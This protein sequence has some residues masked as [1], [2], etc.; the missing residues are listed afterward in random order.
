[1]AGFTSRCGAGIQHPLARLRIDEPGRQLRARVLH[2]L[3][4]GGLDGGVEGGLQAQQISQII[5][6]GDSVPMNP[7]NPLDA[8]NRRIVIMVLNSV[9]EAQVEAQAEAGREAGTLAEELLPSTPEV[10]I[11]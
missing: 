4:G 8:S 5:G 11:F 10:Q 3:R 6:M 1:M 7:E 9:V 2:E